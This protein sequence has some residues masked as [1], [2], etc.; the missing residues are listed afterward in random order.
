MKD[1]Y[2]QM[3]GTPPVNT[4]WIDTWALFE[5]GGA[6]F[7]LH[8]IPPEYAGRVQISSPPKARETSLVKDVPAERNRLEAMKSGS[9]T[10][11]RHL[12][13]SRGDCADW[14]PIW[15][16]CFLLP[17]QP[18]R[19]RRHC[20]APFDLLAGLFRNRFIGVHLRS[21]ASRLNPRA[22]LGQDGAI[23]LSGSVS[24]LGWKTSQRKLSGT[25]ERR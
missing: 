7:A 16:C 21:S 2:E 25:D 5:V 4:D 13:S 3:L 22:V 19:S 24:R 15:S 10:N 12:P 8:A 23:D 14:S 17:G 6:R 18:G 20:E 1:F 9:G 11:G